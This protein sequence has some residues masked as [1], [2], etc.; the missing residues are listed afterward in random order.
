MNDLSNVATISALIG[1]F[2]LGTLSAE[3][4]VSTKT[5]EFIKALLYFISVHCSTFAAIS[6]ALLYRHLNFM[7]EEKAIAWAFSKS[8][9]M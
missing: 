2:A 5:L 9:T 4:L 3:E 6:S 7:D 8:I 1:G